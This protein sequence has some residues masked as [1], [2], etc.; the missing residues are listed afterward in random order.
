MSNHNS[1]SAHHHVR[2]DEPVVTP[3]QPSSK[4]SASSESI[5]ARAYEKFVARGRTH[6]GDREDWAEAERELTRG[7]AGK[8]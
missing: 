6:G 3:V 2:P 7:E 1:H 8:A 4:H 5:A